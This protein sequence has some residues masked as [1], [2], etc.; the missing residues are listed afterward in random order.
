MILLTKFVPYLVIFPGY[1]IFPKSLYIEIQY[2]Q[3]QTD[4]TIALL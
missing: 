3:T 4:V 2:V 1:V